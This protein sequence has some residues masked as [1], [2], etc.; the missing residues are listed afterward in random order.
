M[1]AH[2]FNELFLFEVGDALFPAL[3][4]QVFDSADRLLAGAHRWM[5][6]KGLF[7]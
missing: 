4:R 5:T 7:W 6:V 2:Y 3:A 1:W